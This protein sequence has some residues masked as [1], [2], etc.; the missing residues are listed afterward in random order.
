MTESI[1]N[2]DCRNVE[3]GKNEQLFE[4]NCED[5]GILMIYAD[6]STYRISS[7]NRNYNQQKLSENLIR[8]GNYLNL[9]E[10][11]I[12]MDKTKISE[13]MIKQ[14]RG[15]MTGLPPKL[16][17]IDQQGNPKEVLD[18]ISIRIL[19]GNIQN[20]FIWSSHLETGEK[21]LLPA[22]RKTLGM[23]KNTGRKLPASCRNTLVRGLLISK[24][25]YLI[26]M[27]GGSTENHKLKAQR[28]LNN[29]ARWVTGKS[30]KTR[31]SSLTEETGWWTITELTDISSATLIWKLIHLD[32]PWNIRRKMK[33]DNET[34]KFTIT[35]PRINFTEQN[36]KLRAS[37]K[38]NSLPDYIR[39]NNILSSFKRQIKEWIKLGRH[40]DPREQMDL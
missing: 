12:N 22:I 15:R 14:K 3:H 35:E 37:R 4:N 23:L 16:D 30:K 36:F 26:S 27:W 10:L 13:C 39:T 19:G 9:N 32:K 1:R 38:W 8:I 29:A 21:T 18:S 34:M 5:C 2:P 40:K 24:M 17:V 33:L 20:N 31:I 28:I 6:D 7:R 11:I 25:N